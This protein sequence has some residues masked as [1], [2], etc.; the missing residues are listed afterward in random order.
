[1]FH[2]GSWSFRPWIFLRHHHVDFKEIRVSLFVNTTASE[3]AGYDSDFKVPVL[4]DG[5]LVVRDSLSI[6]EYVSEACLDN[7]G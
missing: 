2:K 1:M 5:D 7:R 6:P 4:K 3:L